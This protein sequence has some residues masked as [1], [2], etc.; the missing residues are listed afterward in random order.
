MKNVILT[1]AILLLLCLAPMPYGYY[2]FIRLVST[3]VFVVLAYDYYQKEKE[4]LTILFSALAILFQPF[5]KIVLSRDAWNTIDVFVA[6]ILII[7]S[8]LYK[9]E[10]PTDGGRI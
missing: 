4:I 9:N 7:L 1:M 3:I 5:I 2:M 10:Y 8:F 6:I